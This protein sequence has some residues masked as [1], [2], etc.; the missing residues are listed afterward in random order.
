M[1]TL[2]RITWL[3]RGALALVFAWHGLV[4]KILYLSPGEVQMIQAHGL[5][6]PR[7]LL[8]GFGVLEVAIALWLVSGIARRASLMVCA[9]MLLGLLVDVAVVLPMLMV[10][11][12]NPVSLNIACL[13]LCWVAWIAE[14]PSNDRGSN[15][16]AD[17][18]P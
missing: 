16:P 14:G 5:P 17:T 9:A 12:F 3:A 4:P 7:W 8:M 15:A 13:A 6:E 18:V 2:Q 10:Q 11:A 1:P